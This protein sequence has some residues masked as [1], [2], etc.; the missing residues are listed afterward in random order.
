MSYAPVCR[1]E[2]HLMR[3]ERLSEVVATGKKSRAILAH[4]AAMIFN[5]LFMNT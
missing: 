3:N 5:Y 4:R 2:R 1:V